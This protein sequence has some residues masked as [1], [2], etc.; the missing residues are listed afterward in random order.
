MYSMIIT[1]E[2]CLNNRHTFR[3]FSLY[4]ICFYI[5]IITLNLPPEN[6]YCMDLKKI[7]GEAVEVVRHTGD[8]IAGERTKFSID[9]V[10]EK[11]QHNFV[12]Y[13]DKEAE[14][15]LVGGLSRILPQAGFIV[16][17]GTVKKKDKIYN[18]IIDP[19]DGTTNFIHGSPPYAISVALMQEKEVI[20]G[21]V[22]EIVMSELFYSY[23]GTGA[24]L[25][26]K[27]IHVSKTKSV[28][29]SLIATGFPYNNFTRLESFMHSLEHFFLNSHGVRRLGSAATDL[30]YVA[31]GRYDTFYEY[32]LN[33][34]DVAAGAFIVQ[35]AGGRV[36]DFKGEND[37]IFGNEIVASNNEVFDEFRRKVGEFMNE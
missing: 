9:K 37:Y 28:D 18:W 22:L 11:G 12:S 17:E 10:E 25:N 27:E 6:I 15:K 32:N 26:G 35:Q 19:L 3:L 20:L 8:F 14:S 16:E 21:I 2:N 5:L 34:W 31:C 13:V 29:E 4:F 36:S 7:C 1:R 33:P 30:A 24:F 23:K